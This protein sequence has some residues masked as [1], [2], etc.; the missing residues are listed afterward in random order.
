[1]KQLVLPIA[2]ILGTLGLSHAALPRLAYWIGSSEQAFE[3][4]EISLLSIQD[5]HLH[6]PHF[7]R[8]CFG[9][10]TDQERSL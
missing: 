3:H 10:C 4:A 7:H 6:W 8:P 2:T 5:L 9:L 1:M